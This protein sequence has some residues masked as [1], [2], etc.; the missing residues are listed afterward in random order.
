MFP[1][2]LVVIRLAHQMHG[3]TV[4]VGATTRSNFGLKNV[5]SFSR[6]IPRLYKF[7]AHCQAAFLVPSSAQS[8]LFGSLF[9]T[10]G[11]FGFRWFLF[12]STLDNFQ[13]WS[14][15]F[16]NFGKSFRSLC[17]SGFKDVPSEIFRL[18]SSEWTVPRS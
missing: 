13:R 14:Q 8:V 6:Y 5:A 3:G 15:L 11:A 7:L 18:S 10:V 1:I 16:P 17:I 9:S 12:M 2:H 4:E